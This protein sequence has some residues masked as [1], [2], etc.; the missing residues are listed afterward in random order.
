MDTG[1]PAHAATS[2]SNLTHMYVAAL[3]SIDT[4]HK[5]NKAAD[6]NTLIEWQADS[7]ANVAASTMDCTNTYAAAPQSMDTGPCRKKGRPYTM[8]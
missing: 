3:L 4:Q 2:T 7:P 1:S 8:L 6:I 5:Q